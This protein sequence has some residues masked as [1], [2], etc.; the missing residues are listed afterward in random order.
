MTYKI[1]LH[2]HTRYSGDNDADP[3]ETIISAIEGGLHGIVI[4]EHYSFAASEP[5]ER[6][7][8]KY[9]EQLLI[10]RG[11][12]F[13]AQ[14]GHCLIF[15]VDTDRLNMKYAPIGDVVRA[16]LQEG[17]VAIP[18]HPYRSVNGL[19]DA[20]RT[21]RG[22]TALE[23]CN[24]CNMHAFNVKAIETARLLRLPYTGGSDSH[25]PREVG[26]CYTEFE[27]QVTSENF[28]E[29]LK[30]GKY[31]GVDTRRISGKPTD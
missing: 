14:E 13:S 19:G 7:K 9:R 29:R 4:T 27:E 21:V 24:G 28:I 1:D 16:V 5:L 15:G 26:S 23:G 2:V 12:E 25:A 31:Q 10:I 17:G 22:I 8:E 20:V 6:L 30:Q 11:V 18:S 3:E